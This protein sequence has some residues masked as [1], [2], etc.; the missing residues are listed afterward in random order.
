MT[1]VDE[2]TR[3]QLDALARVGC[4]GDDIKWT[5][6]DEGLRQ[7]L[8]AFASGMEVSRMRETQSKS[9]PLAHLRGRA[10]LHA[11]QSFE[12]CPP[13]DPN[14]VPVYTKETT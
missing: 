9:T 11:W 8:A 14:A 12:V 1:I 3:A 13:D 2:L 6:S 5:F 10:A 7:T 4:G